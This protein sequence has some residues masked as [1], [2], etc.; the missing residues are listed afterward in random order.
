MSAQIIILRLL[1]WPTYIAHILYARRRCYRISFALSIQTQ[2]L[3][4]IICDSPLCVCCP[5]M[6][7]AHASLCV[8]VWP[9]FASSF[10]SIFHFSPF[11]CVCVYLI[12]SS[13][14]Y[15]VFLRLCVYVFLFFLSYDLRAF[16]PPFVLAMGN[17][18]PSMWVAYGFVAVDGFVCCRSFYLPNFERF[19]FSIHVVLHGLPLCSVLFSLLASNKS[20]WKTSASCYIGTYSE[21][22]APITRIEPWL[23]RREN[24][25]IPEEK[26]ATETRTFV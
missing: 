11:P 13:I 10:F 15:M 2:T 22:E 18:C 4:A 5:C 20:H 17:E 9:I 19:S 1:L 3:C 16:V 12:S 8:C 6:A 21:R 23:I 14:L 7:C 24:H 26:N 25:F